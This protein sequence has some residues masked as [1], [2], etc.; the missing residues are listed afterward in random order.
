MDKYEGITLHQIAPYLGKVRPSLAR[1]LVL[2][3]SK[4]SEWVWDPFCGSGTIPYEC[5]LLSRHALAG[6]INPYACAVTRAKMHAPASLGTALR[7]LHDASLALRRGSKQAY[8]KVP[9]WVGE[10]F[11]KRTLREALYLS[12]YF[13]ASRQHFN[14][15]CLLGILHHQRPGFLSYPASHLVPYL[16]N[17]HFPRDRFPEA[18]MYRDPVP[19]LAAKMTRM[20]ECPPPPRHSHFA[21]WCKSVYECFPP[22]ASVDSVITSP[23]YMNALDY[24]RDN[25]LRLW[26]I[27][28]TNY[29]LIESKEIRRA[30]SFENELLTVLKILARSLKPGGKCVFILGDSSRSKKR[31]DA[32]EIACDLV[33]NR[34]RQLELCDR[35]SES[36][37]NDR[38][39]RPTGKATKRE[40]VLIFCRSKGR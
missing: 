17:Q 3:Y 37:P 23:P 28:I 30:A 6:D 5:R 20:L 12:R 40:S 16:R 25:R 39:S 35:W 11:H 15:G 38:R 22:P 26:F 18:Y 33:A 21:I 14:L 4:P 8:P 31:Y 29:R 32:A 24:A 9:A 13:A 7:G 10:F 1:E 2:A 34:L 36:I 27:G 19:R